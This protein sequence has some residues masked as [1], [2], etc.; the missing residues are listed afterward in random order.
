MA[1]DERMV[2]KGMHEPREGLAQQGRVQV[3]LAKQHAT[4][5]ARHGWPAKMTSEL[6]N[7]VELISSGHS[8][9]VDARTGSKA[10]THAEHQAVGE[11]KS[12]INLLRNAVPLAVEDAVKAGKHADVSEFHAGQKLGLS[13]P[14]ILGYFDSIAPAVARL[15]DYLKP[16]L[17]GDKPSKRLAALKSSL[18]AKDSTQEASLK[19]LPADTLDVYEAKGR[20]LDLIERLNRIARI[21]FDGQAELIGKFNKDL[22]LRA[23]KERRAKPDAQPADKP[24]VE[25]PQ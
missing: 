1:H 24:S 4:E 20:V 5:L 9:Q 13:T 7:Q 23:R 8:A 18:A 16:Y 21:A 19:G 15:D 17:P 10:D 25:T 22:L 14:K 3:E 2:A 6:A 12:F 11:A